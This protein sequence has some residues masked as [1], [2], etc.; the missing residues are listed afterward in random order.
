MVTCL[1]NFQQDMANRVFV[2]VMNEP[3]SMGIRWESQGGRPGA[4]QLYLATAD[5]IW[6]LSP[7]QVMFMFEGEC[8][9]GGGVE[10]TRSSDLSEAILGVLPAR[11]LLVTSS[12]TPPPQPPRHRPERLRPQLGQRLHHQ[13]R[14]HPEPRPVGRQ[15]LLP[16][17][18][19]QALRRQGARGVGGEWGGGRAWGC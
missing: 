18:G 5:A 11:L 14:G 13:P 2:D 16:G 9:L 8:F 3:D 17:A 19:D 4:Q 10:R 6:Q 12:L 15:P 7:D 1:P